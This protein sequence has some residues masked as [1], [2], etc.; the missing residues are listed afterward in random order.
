VLGIESDVKNLSLDDGEMNTTEGSDSQ[1]DESS[2]NV[3]DSLQSNDSDEIRQS[4]VK[5]NS[6]KLRI[7][8]RKLSA[9]LCANTNAVES[10]GL[11]DMCQGAG[12]KGFLCKNS[13]R[14]I[15][16]RY[17]PKYVDKSIPGI[18]D[19]DTGGVEWDNLEDEDVGEISKRLCRKK[20][21]G[22]V[23]DTEINRID[24]LDP[25]LYRLLVEDD[26]EE[27]EFDNKKQEDEDESFETNFQI[28]EVSSIP[29]SNDEEHHNE[30]SS[31][32]SNSFP[33]DASYDQESISEAD[34][35]MKDKHFASTSESYEN[36]VKVEDPSE[37]SAQKKDKLD[38]SDEDHLFIQSPSDTP[39]TIEST[40]PVIITQDKYTLQEIVYD[41][42]KDELDIMLFGMPPARI[43]KL[44][45]EFNNTLGDPSM[46]HLV[47]LLRENIPDVIDLSWLR[48]KNVQ[49]SNF[50]L[51]KAKE[52][53]VV[54]THILNN[55]LQVLAKSKEI[56]EA[57]AFYEE[58]Y[59]LQNM[60]SLVFGWIGI[61]LKL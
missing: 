12:S 45:Q 21:M 46:L 20:F 41:D 53:G 25:S 35:F 8:A 52:D 29:I 59:A 2:N 22:L 5:V 50:V 18:S 26:E 1:E 40:S 30:K 58:Q 14:L 6:P 13:L 11:G 23:K 28:S 54:D 47:L 4:K 10:R 55:M 39:E 9:L 56:D 19:T 17:Q 36:N 24:D 15:N 57:L 48:K 42:N 16:A 34:Y 27:D 38:A 61:G 43:K 7:D 31:K 49:D 32:L 44:R 3:I 51:N 37:M 33:N 60:S